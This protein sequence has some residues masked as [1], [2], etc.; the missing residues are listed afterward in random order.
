MSLV[1]SVCCAKPN[2]SISDKNAHKN[3]LH[4]WRVKAMQIAPLGFPVEGGIELTLLMK[5]RLKTN[6]YICKALKVNGIT[7]YP[8]VF[9]AQ[10]LPSARLLTHEAIHID[11]VKRVGIF[12]F[13]LRYL[14]EYLALRIKR[15]WPQRGLF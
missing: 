6:S 7:L 15:P 4:P 5:A 11:Q 9:V 2:I 1:L 13:Y 10:K 12:N 3:F 14:R 8:F